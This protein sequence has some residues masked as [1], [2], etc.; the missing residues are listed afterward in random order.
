MYA[1]KS[2]A[3]LL[4]ISFPLPLM[5]DV[6]TEIAIA[7]ALAES[8]PAAA[9]DGSTPATP[10]IGAK[11]IASPPAVVR[12]ETRQV[13]K[14][15]F[16]RVPRL[17]K[18]RICGYTL[19]QER[20]TAM[21]RVPVTTQAADDYATPLD[22]AKRILEFMRPSSRAVL[23]DL[24]SG[25]GRMVVEWSRWTGYPAVGIEQD[26]QRVALSR[27]FARRRGVAHLATF[28]EGDYTTVDLPEA[29][30][31][32]VYQFPEDLAAVKDKLRQYPLVVSYAHQVPG[33]SMTSHNGG[34]FYSWR[35]SEPK[36]VAKSIPSTW[37]GGKLYTP[38]NLPM[39]GR[40]NCFPMCQTIKNALR[41]QGA[42]L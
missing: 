25:D 10:I 14:L 42:N 9:S 37:Y 28:I 16:V 32:Y 21:E 24:G 20:Y 2:L 36:P 7:L 18:G 17:C 3:L 33:L 22:A 5:A 11:E 8:T 23:L 41:A 30:I 12:Y 39:G 1:M 38:Y 34:E 19:K 26:P 6:E 29:D 13:E 15:R 40:C 4:C 27:E 35:K 31:I